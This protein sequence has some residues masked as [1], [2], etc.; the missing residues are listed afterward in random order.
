MCYPP[1]TQTWLATAKRRRRVVESCGSNKQR[2]WALMTCSASRTVC[3]VFCSSR[4]RDHTPSHIHF[5]TER[6]IERP[7]T[8]I[9]PCQKG[10]QLPWGIVFHRQQSFHHLD[11]CHH[12]HCPAQFKV[13]INPHLADLAWCPLPCTMRD[14]IQPLPSTILWGNPFWYN[15]YPIQREPTMFV[16]GNHTS[17][18][19]IG[20]WVQHFLECGKVESMEGR[21]DKLTE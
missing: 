10:N 4:C 21:R 20:H 17:V 15:N 6:S 18:R 19:L 3:T 16:W 8:F 9:F 5:D 7:M 2:C 13:H 12:A 14:P 11:R 1:N